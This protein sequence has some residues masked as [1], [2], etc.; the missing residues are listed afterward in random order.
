MKSFFLVAIFVLLAGICPLATIFQ[1]SAG[2]SASVTVGDSAAD[3]VKAL[4]AQVYTGTGDIN[5]LLCEDVT[6][7]EEAIAGL[8]SVSTTLKSSGATVDMSSM[9]FT[10]LEED[11][12]SATVEV[13]G[14]YTLTVAGLTSDYDVIPVTHTLVRENGVWKVCG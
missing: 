3:T 9:T 2:S 8:E 12:D 13:G 6:A 5:A 7:V 10:T 11:E 1:E 14:K 4:Y